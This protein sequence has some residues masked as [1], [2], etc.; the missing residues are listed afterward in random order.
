MNE[1]KHKTNAMASQEKERRSSLFLYPL[2]QSRSSENQT[3]PRYKS[4]QALSS[5]PLPSRSSSQ[6]RRSTV[7]GSFNHNFKHSQWSCLQQEE[8][9]GHLA[10]E[11]PVCEMKEESVFAGR[12]VCEI[13]GWFGDELC[14]RC[15]RSDGMRRLSSGKRGF[16]RGSVTC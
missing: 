3:I 10:Q 14:L 16:E 8:R 7:R 12:R 5:H 2:P 11:D 4:K 1:S 6:P 9:L 13:L 15:R